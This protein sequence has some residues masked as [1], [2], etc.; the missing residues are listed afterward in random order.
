MKKY[1]LG[2]EDCRKDC[3]RLINDFFNPL[4]EKADGVVMV[5]LLK[6][7]KEEIKQGLKNATTKSHPKT[8]IKIF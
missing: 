3:Y 5:K 2:Y 6:N 7:I 1:K 8:N 4:I